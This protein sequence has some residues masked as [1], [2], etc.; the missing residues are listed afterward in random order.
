MND[1]VSRYTS[2]AIILHWL[3]GLMILCMF[4]LGWY[5]S[6][7]PKDL[8]KTASLDLFGLGIYTFQPA[9]P[10]SPRTFYFNLHKSVGLTILALVF[11]RLFWRLTHTVP[12]MPASMQEWQAKAA[13]LAHKGLYLMML[14]LPLSG[15]VMSVYS[16]YGI[17][18]FGIK[19]V[20][21]LDNNPL[22]EQFKEV[23][24]IAGWV[25]LALIILHAS[26]ALKHR[27]W[28]KD[29]IWGRMSLHG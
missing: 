2:I 25:F 7:L 24:E 5:M 6:E 13:R 19:L 1:S 20:A 16:K 10:M 22:R 23:H 14:A 11:F 27:F 15:I 12:A 18:W 29:E 26:A 3:I 17:A 4:A 8:P 21:G 28:D 9:E